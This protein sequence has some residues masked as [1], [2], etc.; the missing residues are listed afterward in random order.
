MTFGVLVGDYEDGSPIPLV[1]SEGSR[2]AWRKWC[3]FLHYLGD[4]GMPVLAQLVA[5]RAVGVDFIYS[6]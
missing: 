6:L 5:D 4:G 2:K 3:H 1:S